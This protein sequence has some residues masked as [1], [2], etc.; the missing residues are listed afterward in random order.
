MHAKRTWFK[1]TYRHLRLLSRPLCECVRARASAFRDGATPHSSR[2]GFRVRAGSQGNSPVE[3]YA[4]LSRRR[5][6]QG[7]EATTLKRFRG[8]LRGTTYR[9]SRKETRRRKR[10]LSR[11]PL[12]KTC[13]TLFAGGGWVGVC[14][15]GRVEGCVGL[16]RFAG[17]CRWCVW[18][19]VRERSCGVQVA[20]P[21]GWNRM[22]ALEECSQK[23]WVFVGDVGDV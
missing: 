23:R 3:V 21:P 12:S 13:T 5:R 11:K 6:R 17:F 22:H 16:P 18:E 19:W 9:R 4:V 2:A 20:V 14:W 7:L 8:A 10:N 1:A 15:G